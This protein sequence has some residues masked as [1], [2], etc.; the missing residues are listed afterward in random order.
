MHF[1]I[2]MLVVVVLTID[3]S[4]FFL[5][6]KLQYILHLILNVSSG[7]VVPLPDLNVS[8]AVDVLVYIQ[9]IAELEDMMEAV[10]Q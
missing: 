6:I 3:Y 4:R 7:L 1:P 2:P 9:L 5:F 8:V 10:C